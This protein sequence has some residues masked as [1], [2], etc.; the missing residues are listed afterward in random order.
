MYNTKTKYII[1]K[2]DL[3]IKEKDLTEINDLLNHVLADGNVLYM[4]L[5][6]FHWNLSGDNFMELHKL[7]EEQYD[8]VAEAIDEVA[9]R[10]STLG[11]VAIGTTSE[12]A[13]LSLLI[14]NPG[15]IP[16]NQEMI[17]ELVNDHETIVK[18]LRKFVDDTEEKYGDKGTSDFLTGLMQA[19]EKMA[20]KL[21]KYFKGS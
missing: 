21:R 12:F 7:F 6:K 9:E 4:K 15:K 19:H 17:K 20:W 5:R 18:S 3:G 8:A 16:T 13:E 11:G 14:E 10:I 2:P 1:M